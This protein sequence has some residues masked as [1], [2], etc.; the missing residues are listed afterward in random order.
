MNF[1]RFKEF[2]IGVSL[3]SFGD[4]VSSGHESMSL[5]SSLLFWWFSLLSRWSLPLVELTLSDWCMIV[6]CCS[7]WGQFVTGSGLR[8]LIFFS[9]QTPNW[10][11]ILRAPLQR[12][13]PGLTN[14]R[15]RVLAPLISGHQPSAW[16]GAGSGS[17][18]INLSGDWLHPN[19][20]PHIRC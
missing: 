20:S 9:V 8:V 17:G 15:P 3:L 7:H 5:S 19:Y 2:M 1:L 16:P 10:F 4:V 18:D 11:P 6:N 13:W 14:E 12:H